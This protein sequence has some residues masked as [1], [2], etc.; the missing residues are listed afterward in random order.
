M[1]K[2]V[3]REL[4]VI[5]ADIHTAFD[6]ETA[7][8]LTIGKLLI[9]AKKQFKHGAWLPWLDGEFSLTERT[10]QNYMKAH[11]WAT[12]NETRF[13]FTGFKLSPSALYELASSDY[14]EE[15]IKT[16]LEE[17][18]TKRVGT[19]RIE[20]IVQAAIAAAEPEPEPEPETISEDD[21]EQMLDNPTD[22]PP[23]PQ[24][25]PEQTT[26]T[27]ADAAQA[28]APKPRSASVKAQADRAETAPPLQPG[29]DVQGKADDAEQSADQRRALYESAEALAEFKKGFDA[30]LRPFLPKMIVAHWDDAIAY[31]NAS[32]LMEQ[33]WADE[34]E[35]AA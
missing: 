25:P 27:K 3:P 5:A 13:V 17:A 18:K 31:M 9:E 1:S 7:N 34:R 26:Q 2:V 21:I 12:K 20:A 23:G 29:I 28:G 16:I 8:V 32:R 6:T 33:T 11:R 14:S 19:Y 30:T 22:T 15:I 4:A 24:E 35:R 10:A